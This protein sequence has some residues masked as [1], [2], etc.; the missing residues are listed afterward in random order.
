MVKVVARLRRSWRVRWDVLVLLLILLAQGARVLVPNVTRGSQDSATA[1]RK[2]EQ[3]VIRGTRD[4]QSNLEATSTTAAKVKPKLQAFYNMFNPPSDEAVSP[5]VRDL[6]SE[7]LKQMLESYAASAFD[8]VIH[9][10]SMG[11]VV[12]DAWVQDLCA[13]VMAS[14]TTNNTF[15]CV[16]VARYPV[17]DEMVTLTKVRDYCLAHESELVIYFH[18]KGSFHPSVSNDNWRRSITAALSSD[19]CLAKMREKDLGESS[20]CDTCSLL[21]DPL[22]G[23]HYPGNMFA[24]RCSYI[25]KLLPLSEYQ[26]R[27]Q[28]VDNW[29]FRDQLPKQIFSEEGGLFEFKPWNMG[30]DRYESEHWLAGHPSIRPCEV[31][32][33]AHM[34]HWSPESG[35]LRDF[36]PNSTTRHEW[37]L[38]PHFP[39]GH[40]NWWNEA[41]HNSYFQRP[42]ETR[43]CDYFLLRGYLYKWMTYYN[44]TAR[45]DSW[46]WNWFP[47]GDYWRTMVATVGPLEATHERHCLNQSVTTSP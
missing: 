43:M 6:I 38:A 34:R 15:Q 23:P 35:S 13:S 42:S 31:A 14:S 25:A 2:P 5:A 4:V 47:D 46:V 44:A 26:Q 20:S 21:F 9:I 40:R 11:H 41:I 37:S 29:I 36:G 27:H 30:R 45:N 32:T 24:A 19:H 39:F 1:K 17:G 16:L 33:H 8:L 12:D 18:N 22:P 10:I 3:P 7:Q 28:V